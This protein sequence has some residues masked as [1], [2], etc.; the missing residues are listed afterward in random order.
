M[1]GASPLTAGGSKVTVAK[2]V[3]VD[4]RGQREVLKTN[5]ITD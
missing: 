1:T 5:N 3:S 2:P 4:V